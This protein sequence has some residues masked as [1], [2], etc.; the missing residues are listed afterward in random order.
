MT[1]RRAATARG[2]V[3]GETVVLS[4]HSCPSFCHKCPDMGWHVMPGCMGTAAWAHDQ[5][6]MSACDCPVK[7]VYTVPCSHCQGT[8]RMDAPIPRS[9]YG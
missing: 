5:D 9:P 7:T 8:G 6:D 4:H 3:A 2:P 1:A